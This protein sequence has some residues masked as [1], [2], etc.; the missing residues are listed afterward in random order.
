MCTDMFIDMCIDVCMGTRIDMRI[1]KCTD[2]CVDMRI[3]M[4]IDVCIEMCIDLC[5][6]VCTDV[7]IRRVYRHAHRH[8]YRQVCRHVCG[9]VSRH[10]RSQVCG[11]A[12][13]HVSPRR[14]ESFRRRIY[15]GQLFGSILGNFSAHAD[16]QRRRARSGIGG[17]ASERSR[18]RRVF[19]PPFGSGHGPS[20]FAVGTLQHISYGPRRSPLA[21]SNMLVMATY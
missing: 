15:F 14:S 13:R 16:G 7:C 18:A 10:V 5:T 3:D 8:A 4:C 12:H 19:R 21:C 2:M 6:D 1:D 20:A 17:V 11:H 9:H